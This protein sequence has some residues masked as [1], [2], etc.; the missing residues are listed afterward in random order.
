MRKKTSPIENVN[1]PFNPDIMQLGF[2]KRMGSTPF[3]C[4]LTFVGGRQSFPDRLEFCA[5]QNYRLQVLR[6]RHPRVAR[7][8]DWSQLKGR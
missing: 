6:P 2:S 4:K 7:S 3:A 8:P 5:G 1:A